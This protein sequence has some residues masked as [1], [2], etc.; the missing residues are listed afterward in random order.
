MCELEERLPVTFRTSVRKLETRMTRYFGCALLMSLLINFVL[1]ASWTYEESDQFGP[2]NWG[3]LSPKCDGVRQSPININPV[4][5]VKASGYGKISISNINKRPTGIT[6]TNT[7][8][9]V[10]IS[11]TFSDGV[12]PRVTGGPLNADSYVFQNLH[13][14]WKSEHTVNY[15]Q[16]EAEVHLVFWNSKYGSFGPASLRDDGLAVLGFLYTVEFKINEFLTMRLFRK[17]PDSNVC[18]A[19]KALWIVF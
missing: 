16:Y 6:Y 15:R 17:I 11:L 1:S 2:D 9:G 5:T 4:K 7:G 18:D 12:Q 13:F 14:H 10:T 19:R 3:L 8:H